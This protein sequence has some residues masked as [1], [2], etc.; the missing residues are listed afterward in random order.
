MLLI[1]KDVSPHFS[2]RFRKGG[3]PEHVPYRQTVNGARLQ[4]GI[5]KTYLRLAQEKL[6]DQIELLVGTV[7]T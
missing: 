6:P 3:G 1:I 7:R 5:E 2:R 4:S